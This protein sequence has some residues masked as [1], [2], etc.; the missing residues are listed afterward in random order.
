MTHWVNSR[1]FLWEN[2]QETMGKPVENPMKYGENLQIVVVFQGKYGK[3][4]RKASY[5]MVETCS[6]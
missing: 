3:I 2:P 1:E 4:Y 6:C 5:F